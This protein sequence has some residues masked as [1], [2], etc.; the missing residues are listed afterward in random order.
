MYS[1]IDPNTLFLHPPC[2]FSS[3]SVSPPERL[4]S[5]SLLPLV[6]HDVV[7][8]WGDYNSGIVFMRVKTRYKR[9]HL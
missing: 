3:I 2:P 4:P 9:L 6:S 1:F 8:N 7:P 5:P